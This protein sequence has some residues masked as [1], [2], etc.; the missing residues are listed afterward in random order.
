MRASST[1]YQHNTFFQV[2]G[3]QQQQTDPTMCEKIPLK[4]NSSHQPVSNSNDNTV[5][6]NT[7]GDTP[8][9]KVANLQIPLPRLRV[10]HHNGRHIGETRRR[11][12]HRGRSH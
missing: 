2:L 5:C 10:F 7:C 4:P 11:Q 3:C 9:N 12:T 8:G 1:L 6:Q